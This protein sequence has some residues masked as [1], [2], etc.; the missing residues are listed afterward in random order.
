MI[1]KN[2]DQKM[3]CLGILEILGNFWDRISEIE[4]K[5]G[6]L[7]MTFRD[8]ERPQSEGKEN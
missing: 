6:E 2:G 5:V 1:K 8:R 3:K 7:V 4:R